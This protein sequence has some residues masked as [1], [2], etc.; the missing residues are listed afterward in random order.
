LAGQSRCTC[1]NVDRDSVGIGIRNG[2]DQYLDGNRVTR[3]HPTRAGDPADGNVGLRI[4]SKEPDT[5]AG[6][7]VSRDFPSILNLAVTDDQDRP[8]RC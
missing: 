8:I 4:A 1:Q 2:L 7:N 5:G 6:E 3:G